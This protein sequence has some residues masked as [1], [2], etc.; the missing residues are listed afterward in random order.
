MYNW[1]KQLK[2][3]LVLNIKDNRTTYIFFCIGI[4]VVL[5]LAGLTKKLFLTDNLQ[6]LPINT[7]LIIFT[8]ITFIVAELV[9]GFKIIDIFKKKYEFSLLPFN[10]SVII[11]GT[12]I[13]LILWSLINSIFSVFTV[14]ILSWFI[15]KQNTKF[16]HLDF[17]VVTYIDIFFSILTFFSF[18]MFIYLI[19]SNKS[20]IR[21]FIIIVATLFIASYLSK[22]YAYLQENIFHFSNL[23]IILLFLSYLSAV[24]ISSRFKNQ[25]L[26]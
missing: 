21:N 8:G 25:Y 5:I 14:K 19:K 4:Y 10:K 24:Y 11:S 18:F 1:I 9:V 2:G 20:G 7:V 23:S 17:G 16:L 3:Y 26:K 12:Y 22:F 15:T 13:L 6:F